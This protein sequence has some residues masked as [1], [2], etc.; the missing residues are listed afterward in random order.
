MNEIITPSEKSQY[1]G[2]VQSRTAETTAK[3]QPRDE[4]INMISSLLLHIIK[5]SH[6]N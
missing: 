5:I 3:T 6:V 1:W 4:M 2:Q